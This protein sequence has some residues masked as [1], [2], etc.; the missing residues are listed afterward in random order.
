MPATSVNTRNRSAIRV[1][2][3]YT[4]IMVQQ[5]IQACPRPWEKVAPGRPISAQPLRSEA[6]AL[7]AAT[8]GGRFLPPRM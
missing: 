1:Q 7:K 6:P 5:A 2:F 8:L 3:R 4:P